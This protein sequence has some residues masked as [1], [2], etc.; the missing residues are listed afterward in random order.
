MR[1]TKHLIDA[2][3]VAALNAVLLAQLVRFR[4]AFV[5]AALVGIAA[6]GCNG[7][8]SRY[9]MND[10][11]YAKKYA[12]GAKRG[13]L[14]GKAKQA[15]DARH[16]AG[17]GGWFV[18]GGTQYRS[19]SD[20]VLGGAEVGFESYPS[21]WFSQRGSLAAYW[22]EDDGYL[23]ADLGVRAQLPAR[24]T[25]FVGAGVLAGVSR[26]LKS[27]DQDGLD[28]DDDERIDELG[29]TK[30]EFDEALLACYPEVGL[31]A[32]LNGQWRV[33]GFGRYLVT[34]RGRDQD[35]WLIGG[36][37][38]YFPPRPNFGK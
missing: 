37:L 18:G 8:K 31:H 34:D 13:D 30:S 7:F 5:I 24:V 16:V 6:V 26:T 12:D 10:P 4:A 20:S 17:L 32:W 28:N 27:A 2:D 15:V 1:K 25:P 38:T 29:E 14:L 21:S 23:G 33:S 3:P 35:D 36:Q 22:G 11:V 9:A 19:Q